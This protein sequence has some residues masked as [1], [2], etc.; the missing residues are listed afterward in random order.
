MDL[1]LYSQTKGVKQKYLLYIS[2]IGSVY[3]NIDNGNVQ[4]IQ[5]HNWLTGGESIHLLAEEDWG[6]DLSVLSSQAT[7]GE[8]LQKSYRRYQATEGDDLQ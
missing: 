6:A 4:Y 5:S 3:I 8:D 7:E 2:S 1:L